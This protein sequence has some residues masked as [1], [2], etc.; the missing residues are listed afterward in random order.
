MK[1]MNSK[2]KSPPKSKSNLIKSKIN[3]NTLINSI[4]LNKSIK[5]QINKD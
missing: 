4:K 3:Q 5:N 2:L 1:I